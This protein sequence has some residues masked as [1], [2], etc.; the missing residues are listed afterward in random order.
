MVRVVV[1]GATNRFPLVD[2]PSPVPPP[3]DR[4]GPPIRLAPQF[5]GLHYLDLTE[6]AVTEKQGEHWYRERKLL[7]HFDDKKDSESEDSDTDE[8]A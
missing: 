5:W 2:S 6:T 4:P 7:V 1:Q 3:P 8:D